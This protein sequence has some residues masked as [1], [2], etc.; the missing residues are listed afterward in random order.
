MTNL[1]TNLIISPQKFFETRSAFGELRARVTR[2]TW[3]MTR[4]FA[5]PCSYAAN[6]L[7][8]G[9]ERMFMRPVHVHLHRQFKVGL[10]SA[11]GPDIFQ[12][13]QNFRSVGARFLL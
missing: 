4:V 10:E 2:S 7:E 9:V 1:L 13:V 6:Y 12:T 3:P 11:A 5:P 8:E